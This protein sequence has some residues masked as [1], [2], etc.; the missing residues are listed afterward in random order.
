MQTCVSAVATAASAALPPAFNI[1]T[2]PSMAAEPVVAVIM[3]CSAGAACAIDET[4]PIP[5]KSSEHLRIQTST[6]KT[7]RK[8]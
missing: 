3:P 1:S 4:M 7:Q 5:S 2:P 8:R 6:G